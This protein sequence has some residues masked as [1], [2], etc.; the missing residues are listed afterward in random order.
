MLD[1]VPCTIA[2]QYEPMYCAGANPV[3]RCHVGVA[4]SSA[5][6]MFELGFLGAAIQLPVSMPKSGGGGIS[7]LNALSFKLKLDNRYPGI[8]ADVN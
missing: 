4:A 3:S 2:I 5:L 1:S 8:R 7:A 6:G